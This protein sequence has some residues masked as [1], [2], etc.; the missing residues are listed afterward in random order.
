MTTYQLS[1]GADS[2]EA[3]LVDVM[4]IDN[5]SLSKSSS[6]AGNL[7]SAQDSIYQNCTQFHKKSV[8]AMVGVIGKPKSA[9]AY[10]N[11]TN[12]SGLSSMFQDEEPFH[13]VTDLGMKS[14]TISS[15]E[16]VSTH[17]KHAQLHRDGFKHQAMEAGSRESSGPVAIPSSTT[18][19]NGSGTN[20]TYRLSESSSATSAQELLASSAATSD[21]PTISESRALPRA[22][23]DSWAKIAATGKAVAEPPVG[24]MSTINSSLESLQE[25]MRVVWIANLPPTTTLLDVSCRIDVG[26]IMSLGLYNDISPQLAGRSAC[27]IF[28]TAETA[29]AFVSR[30]PSAFVSIIPTKTKPVYGAVVIKPQPSVAIYISEHPFP[31]DADLLSMN[32][33]A[34]A[35]RRI[36]WSRARLFHDV[37]L[38]KFKKDLRD[39]VGVD[40]LELVHFYNPGEA[41]AVFASVCVAA[42]AVQWFRE[43]ARIS[44]GRYDG[45]DVAFVHDFNE[46]PAKL[47]SQYGKDGK[48][49]KLAVTIGIEG[50][51][52]GPP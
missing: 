23:L 37:P 43:Q 41:T 16:E 9:S 33:P 35:R 50:L 22:R 25:Q 18:P 7:K 11:F 34:F 51:F 32:A 1:S 46:A 2:C 36:K 29:A 38:A 24:L 8:E 17:M 12:K 44:G 26:P 45:V 19:P 39:V 15:A 4:D 10:H 52:S 3:A 30:A 48:V 42:R 21:F 20:T 6:A 14:S 47:H 27:I 28:Q 31:L 40:N 5:D 49:K 13:G